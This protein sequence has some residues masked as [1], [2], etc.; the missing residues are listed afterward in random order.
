VLEPLIRERIAAESETLST[1]QAAE[2]VG[3]SRAT[4]VRF[5]DEGRLPFT[6][7]GT[8]RRVRLADVLAFKAAI[9]HEVTS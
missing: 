8:H 5:L 2:M 6:K 1:T 4:M 9:T 3:V 7:P